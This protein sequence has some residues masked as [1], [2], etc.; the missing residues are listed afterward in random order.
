MLSRSLMRALGNIATEMH[1]G[2]GIRPSL[3][4]FVAETEVGQD[5]ARGVRG[6]DLKY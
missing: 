2:R 6:R 1:A 5:R 3:T 4:S